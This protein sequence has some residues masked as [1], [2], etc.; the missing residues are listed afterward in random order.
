MT[1]AEG[2]DDEVFLREGWTK[3]GN[4]WIKDDLVVKKG[5]PCDLYNH[6]WYNLPGN[7][8]RKCEKCELEENIR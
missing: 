2:I 4:V 8:T 7:Y 1:K 3:M 5:E 6:K